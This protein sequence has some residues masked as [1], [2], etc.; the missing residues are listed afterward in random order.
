MD[1]RDFSNKLAEATKNMTPGERE[2]LRK[3][4]AGISAEMSKTDAAPNAAAATTGAAVETGIP[5]GPTQ[6]H[7]ALKENFLKQVPSISTHR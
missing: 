4:F 5:N 1:I 3:M 2:S 6:R 7:I